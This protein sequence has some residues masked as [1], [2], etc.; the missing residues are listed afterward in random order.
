MN[1]AS[2]IAVLAAR[3]VTL[4]WDG[5]S[6]RVQAPTQDT[7]REDLR[8]LVAEHRSALIEALRDDPRRMVRTWPA[9]AREAW[10][11]RAA[12]IEYD[13]GVQRDAAERA[14]HEDVRQNLPPYVIAAIDDPVVAAIVDA[15]DG[16]VLDVCPLPDVPTIKVLRQF[17]WRPCRKTTGLSGCAQWLGSSGCIAS[18]IAERTD[19]FKPRSPRVATHK[20][21][22]SEKGGSHDW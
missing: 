4:R 22:F 1:P 5:A 12:I 11:E 20:P 13:G 6:L 9:D 7:Y 19:D 21:C 15:F 3:G 2:V 8:A 14:A 17:R 10:E 16:V 18:D